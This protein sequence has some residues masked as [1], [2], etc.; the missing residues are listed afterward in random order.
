MPKTD[1]H[2]DA[3]PG[4]LERL[5][6]EIKAPIREITKGMI[7]GTERITKYQPQ[8]ERLVRLVDALCLVGK[9][10]DNECKKY[11]LALKTIAD[12]ARAWGL[13]E[14]RDYAKA[15]ID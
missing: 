1:N 8:F 4:R 12:P 15:I 10:R 6:E 11:R 14:M 7:L 2:T 3:V 5:P 9:S 13:S